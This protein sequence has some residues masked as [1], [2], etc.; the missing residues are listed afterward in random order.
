MQDD[1]A[2]M[3]TQQETTTAADRCRKEAVQWFVILDV[4]EEWMADPRNRTEYEAI[5]EMCRMFRGM[6][7]PPLP[8]TAELEVDDS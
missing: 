4:W 8:S 1:G 2:E 7:P 6:P 5:V 3:T